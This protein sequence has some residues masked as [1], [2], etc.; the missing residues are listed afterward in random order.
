LKKDIDIALIGVCNP[1]SHGVIFPIRAQS[2]PIK[3][4]ALCMNLTKMNIWRPGEHK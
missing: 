3:V 2:R 4:E 1:I